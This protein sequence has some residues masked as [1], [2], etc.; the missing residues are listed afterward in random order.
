L[1]QIMS[2]LKGSAAH[3]INKALGRRGPVWQ[4][5]SFDHVLRSDESAVSKVEYI[6]ENPVRRGLVASVEEYR[7][8]WREWLEGEALGFHARSSMAI[9]AT[10]GGGC[11]TREEGRRDFRPSSMSLNQSQARA[12]VLHMQ[13]GHDPAPH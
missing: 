4:D 7:W 5:E 11:A 3:A 13:E 10:A 9:R 8:I 1:A 2:G 6:C 12:P